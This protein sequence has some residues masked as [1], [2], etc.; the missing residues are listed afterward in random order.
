MQNNYTL[1]TDFYELTMAQ[2]YFNSDQKNRIVYFDG[3]F[4]KLPFNNSYA[5]MGGVDNIIKYIK[6]LRFT[7]KDIEYLKSL[8]Q[9]TDDFLD[10]LKN[11][12]FNGTIK[13]IPD[14]TC[15]FP[16]EP[17]ITV[18]ANIIEAQIIETAVLAYLNACIK[19][20]T[21]AKMITEAAKGKAVMEFG[22]R[23]A[24]GPDAS[25]LASKCSIIGGCVGTSN[26]MAAKEYGIK[27]MGTIANSFI[28]SEQREYD[29]FMKYA[30]A[31][32]NNAVFLVDTY[33]TLK[34]G[35]PNAIRVAK[36]FLV[37]NGYEFKGIRIDSGDL[38]YL[39]KQAR[40]MLDEAG[41]KNTKICLSNGLNVDSINSLLEKNTPVDSFGIG[42]NI[43]SPKERVGVVYKLVAIEEN[44]KIIP[45]IKIS[46]DPLKTVN[47]GYKKIYR[48]YDEN[49]GVA[50]RDI[51]TCHDEIFKNENIKE[52][53][54]IIFDNGKLVYDD[55]LIYEKQDYCN[56]SFKTLPDSIKKNGYD[57]K[58]NV[59]LSN[60]LEE[61]KKQLIK[62]RKYN[63]GGIV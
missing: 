25:I 48:I 53:Q 28:S 59:D 39:S 18:R 4:R 41:F 58:F 9:F 14:G 37:P 2:S 26:V 34:S 19:F 40:I 63:N 60:K 20:T 27:V 11:F 30:K 22:S 23:R 8:N 21:S 57:K 52:L 6:N 7:E 55:P 50:I 12:K 15:V 32:P 47:P 10:Y 46:G 17:L 31:Y 16:N 45:K 1:M 24:D 5:I 33:D 35:I 51:I 62:E 61:T 36:D 38:E 43:S 13:M 56:Y 44:K 49:N 29:A 54:R 3:F 42:D